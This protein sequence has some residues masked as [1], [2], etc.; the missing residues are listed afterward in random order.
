MA[1]RIW[2]FQFRTKLAPNLVNSQSTAEASTMPTEGHTMAPEPHTMAT[3]RCEFLLRS[4]PKGHTKATQW[5]HDVV[6][7][8]RWPYEGQNG[9]TNSTR[10]WNFARSWLRAIFWHAKDFATVHEVAAGARETPPAVIRWLK[11]PS[12]MARCVHDQS[13]IWTFPLLCVHIC[14]ISVQC[15]ACFKNINRFL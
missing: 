7:R 15:D 13:R 9:H 11:I 14:S 4:L 1:I 2:N 5:P 6:L 12:R 8:V 3:R 10:K